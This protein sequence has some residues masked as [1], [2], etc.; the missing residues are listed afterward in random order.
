MLCLVPTG[1]PQAFVAFFSIL[2]STAHFE[3]QPVSPHLANGVIVD[4]I[5]SCRYQREGDW[6]WDRDTVSNSTF[7]YSLENLVAAAQYECFVTARNDVGEG[8]AS[9]PILFATPAGEDIITWLCTLPL[10]I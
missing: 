9:T 3:W 7:T 6:H 5:I 1:S 8:P 2:Q 4:Y 10:K